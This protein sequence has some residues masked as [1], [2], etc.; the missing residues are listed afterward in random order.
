MK[1]EGIF[2]TTVEANRS[3]LLEFN[4]EKDLSGCDYEITENLNGTRY[5]A[6]GRILLL[7][8]AAYIDSNQ[9]SID[10]LQEVVD[11]LQA[12]QDKILEKFM[13]CQQCGNFYPVKEK[14]I[15][16][17]CIAVRA[18][19]FCLTGCKDQWDLEHEPTPE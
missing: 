14:G 12:Q 18:E 17:D 1:S 19:G 16:Q 3:S 15:N 4:F 7:K 2:I 11:K 6:R 13:Q 5:I 10:S 9:E 8:G